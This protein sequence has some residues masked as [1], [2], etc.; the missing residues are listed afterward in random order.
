MATKQV[1][2]Y[3][4]ILISCYSLR[5]PGKTFAKEHIKKWWFL[6]NVPPYSGTALSTLHWKKMALL[7]TE[8]WWVLSWTSVTEL[9]GPQKGKLALTMSF[10]F[11]SKAYQSLW[12][13]VCFSYFRLVSKQET[14]FCSCHLLWGIWKIIDPLI[15]LQ[16]G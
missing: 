4:N 9:C 6:R 12:S 15:V 2:K 5:I 11:I 10:F 1:K 14:Q 3:K 16:A 8:I 13:D 7:F